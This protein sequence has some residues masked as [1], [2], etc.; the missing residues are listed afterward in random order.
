MNRN[1]L[2]RFLKQLLAKNTRNTRTH[3]EFGCSST[4]APTPPGSIK[5]TWNTGVG[6]GLLNNLVAA[7]AGLKELGVKTKD[8]QQ[9]RGKPPVV[10]LT[11]RVGF[12][13]P[14]P[15]GVPFGDLYLSTSIEGGRI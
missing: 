6:A 10:S 11:G 14:F 15:E 4:P 5:M 7:G 3:K 1:N 2:T 9:H 13:T 8:E 12:S